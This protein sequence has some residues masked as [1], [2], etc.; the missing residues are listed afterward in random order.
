LTFLLPVTSI[1]LHA[2]FLCRLDSD[3]LVGFV[4]VEGQGAE[5]GTYDTLLALPLLVTS[6]IV[7]FNHKGAPTV[8]HMLS[9]LGVLARA[10]EYIDL[11]EAGSNK[12]GKKKPFGH[13]HVMFRDFSFEGSEEDVYDQ[14]MG[15]EKLGTKSLK[16]TSNDP[17]KAA[18]ERNDIRDLLI[19][20]FESINVWLFKQPSS[21]SNLRAH[22][23][24]PEELVDPSFIQ[25]CKR[26]LATVTGQLKRPKY[27]NGAAL[28]GPKLRTLITQ[29][30][31]QLNEGGAIS[32]PSVFKAMESET[33]V[34]DLFF[35]FFC[36][37]N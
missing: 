35:N 9:Q 4:D 11:G 10:A 33:L 28:N 36:V 32:V 17:Y 8:S 25:T 1:L 20:N 14:L 27:F 15:K 2:K 6:K 5:D 31:S 26:L 3:G 12:K 24:L 13:L 37:L 21:P 30:C 19:A 7:L 29:V 16:P 18:Q 23:E 22:E 34:L